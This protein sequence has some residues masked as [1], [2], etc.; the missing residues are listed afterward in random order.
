MGQPAKGHGAHAALKTALFAGS[1]LFFSLSQFEEEKGEGEVP[2]PFG[3][4]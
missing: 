2:A 4:R 1:L 3:A